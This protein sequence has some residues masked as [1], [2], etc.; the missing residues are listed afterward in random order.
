VAFAPGPKVAVTRSVHSPPLDGAA[1]VTSA[2]PFV[3]LVGVAG[4]PPTTLAQAL[5][6]AVGS[7]LPKVTRSGVRACTVPARLPTIHGASEPPPPQV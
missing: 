4:T 6:Q 7:R 5:V 1:S 2:A 3:P